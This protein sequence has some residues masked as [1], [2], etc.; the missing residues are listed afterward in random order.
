MCFT[1]KD[2]CQRGKELYCFVRFSHELSNPN[3]VLLKGHL[4]M[5][6]IP[7]ESLLAIMDSVSLWQSEAENCVTPAIPASH[8]LSYFDSRLLADAFRISERLLLTLNKPLASQQTVFTLFEANFIPMPFP[9]DPQTALTWNI[10]AP[11][12]APSE[13]KLALSVLYEEQFEHCLG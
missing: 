13:N 7:M 8:L 12:L 3:P 9:D 2:S 6:L 5:W 1:F 11:Y 4:P 10:E